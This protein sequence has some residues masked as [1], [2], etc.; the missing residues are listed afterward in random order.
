LDSDTSAGGTRTPLARPG[1]GAWDVGAYS[2]LGSGTA[3]G[4]VAH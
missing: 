2:Y 4:A 1:S 3:L